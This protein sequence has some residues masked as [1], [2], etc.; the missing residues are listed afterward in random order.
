M[1]VIIM[2][3]CKTPT[4]QLKVL[5]KPSITQIMYMEV[6]NVTMVI[7]T[8]NGTFINILF[9]Y[10][11]IVSRYYCQCHYSVMCK[12]ISNTAQAEGGQRG[13]KVLPVDRGAGPG[14]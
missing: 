11:G 4:L 12:T 8:W 10:L 1:S 13:E 14:T 6:E 3:I 9:G 2:E 7:I 5:N